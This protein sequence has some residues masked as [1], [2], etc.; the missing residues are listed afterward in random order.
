MD[1]EQKQRRRLVKAHLHEY[2]NLRR[3]ERSI[4][5]QLERLQNRMDLR[6]V[7]LTGQPKGTTTYT[8]ADYVA[9]LDELQGQLEEAL[10]D[11]ILAY[12]RIQEEINSMPD[13]LHRVLLI[14]YYLLEK[15]F[16]QIADRLGYSLARIH[17]L[18]AEAL[19]A[20]PLDED[21]IWHSY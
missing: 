18:H 11:T 3:E 16:D 12:K 5:E 2:R 9:E 6:A 14:D 17:H 19:D 13:P 21:A 20:F 8:M 15:P 1:R 10:S 4:L 7:I